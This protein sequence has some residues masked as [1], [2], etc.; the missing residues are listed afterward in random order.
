LS[1]RSPDVVVVGGGI[2]GACIAYLLAREGMVVCIL[3]RDAIGSGSTGHG[4]GVVS[5]VGKDFRPGPH[6]ALGVAAARMWPEFAR[7]LH[8]QGGIDPLYHELEGVSFAVIEEEAEIFRAFLE[9]EDARAELEMRW[10]DVDEIRALEPRLT[11]DAIGG[12]LHRHGQVDGY[13][14]TLAA[15]AAVE[16]L[17][18]RVVLGEATGLQVDAG[19]VVGVEH[20]NGSIPCGH[21]VVA[22]GAWAA[23]SR[24]WLHFPVPV[25]PLH[26]EVLHVVLP[27]EPLHAFV[28]TARHGPILQ[29]KDGIVMVGSIGGVT[30][31]GMDVEARH[32]FDPLDETPPVFDGNPREESRDFMIERA[33]RVMPIIEEAQLVAHLA[34]VRPLSADRM[35]LIGPVPGLEG[36]YLATGHG[37][38]GIH[39]A[40]VT[41]R[42]VADQIV[43]GAVDPAIPAADFLPDRFAAAA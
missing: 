42:I 33:I 43:R 39:L 4:H 29:R 21:V 8:E 11:E 14:A 9:R 20:S 22:A 6:F 28:L 34:G 13:R 31:S 16:R 25:R 12:V 7:Q 10:A 3:E 24:E 5:L 30:M 41:A 37:T 23:R 1:D 2:V 15:V 40:P 17:G 38:K 18:G 19:R 35:P 27:G 26:G 32:V 36:V